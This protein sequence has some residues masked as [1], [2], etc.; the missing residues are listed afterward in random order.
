ML[1]GI[2]KEKARFYQLQRRQPPELVTV[3]VSELEDKVRWPIRKVVP[4]R[5]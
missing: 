5:Y 3:K 4:A 1:G 2:V